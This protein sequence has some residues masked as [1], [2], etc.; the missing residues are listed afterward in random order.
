MINPKEYTF[1]VDPTS[2]DEVQSNIKTLKNNKN[3]GPSSK[4]NKLFKQ[5]K[6][7]LSEPLLLFINL[8]F[9]DGKFSTFFKMEKII[10]VYKKRCKAEITMDQYLYYQL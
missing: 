3:T 2:T 4:P 1:N 7:L 6:E 5:F 8:T 10:P 9:S